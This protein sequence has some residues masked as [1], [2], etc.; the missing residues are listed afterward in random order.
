MGKVGLGL[1]DLLLDGEAV[2]GADELYA[3]FVGVGVGPSTNPLKVAGHRPTFVDND[4]LGRA[5]SGIF[6]DQSNFHGI[7]HPP[8]LAGFTDLLTNCQ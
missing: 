7:L 8:R 4:D 5:L 6:A 1:Y 3:H 2:A